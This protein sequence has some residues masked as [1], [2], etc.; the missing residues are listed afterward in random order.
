MKNRFIPSR[1]LLAAAAIPV[2]LTAL[3]LVEPAWVTAALI[4]DGILVIAAVTDAALGRSPAIEIRREAPAVA[5]LS[6]PIEVRLFVRNRTRRPLH[7]RINQV[8]SAGALATGVPVEIDLAPGAL[9]V[10]SYR[11]R[12]VRRGVEALGPHYVRTWTPFRL[13]IRQIVLP[14]PEEVRVIPDVRGARRYDL[15]ARKDRSAGRARS[16]RL[17][18]GETE[19]ERLRDYSPDD[20]FRRIDW[21]ATAR[22]R[23]L[24]AREFQLEQNQNVV[25]L[26]DCGRLMTAEWGGYA[27]LDYALNAVTML[28]HVAVRRG[29]RVGLLAFTDRIERY[30]PPSGGRNAPRAIVRGTH[31]LFPRLVEPDHE[32]AFRTLRRRVSSRTLV[33]LLTHALDEGTTDRIRRLAAELMPRHLPVVALVRDEALHH[34]AETPSR[35]DGLFTQAAAIELF[36]ARRRTLERM[37]RQGILAVEV[38]P[39]DLTS[40]VVGRYI[41]AKGRALL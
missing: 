6:R 16:R 30:V 33:V 9:E 24:T 21:K 37:R 19:F 28:A 17:R 4:V 1:L 14:G 20:E 27:A 25:C 18:G 36:S 34:C 7:A 8:S 23:R 13:W 38:G 12:P 2:V 15:V 26:V 39:T 41:E 35:G 3:A 5:S 11:L 10:R 29:D 22:R 32:L 31:D 40:A